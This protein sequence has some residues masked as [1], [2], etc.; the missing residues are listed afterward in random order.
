MKNK[1]PAEKVIIFTSSDAV[2]RSV[3]RMFGRAAAL[4]SFC[5][6]F[7]A[8]GAK[9]DDTAAEIKLKEDFA[10]HLE[11]LVASLIL[12]YPSPDLLRRDIENLTNFQKSISQDPAM[13]ITGAKQKEH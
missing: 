7:M 6:E 1:L 2:R 3:E 13:N 11:K 4:L 5:G 8:A 10:P 12:A 9:M